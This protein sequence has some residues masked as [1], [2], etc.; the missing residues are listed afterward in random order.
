MFYGAITND[1]A[2]STL[3]NVPS[4][5]VSILIDSFR[6]QRKLWNTFMVETD[7]YVTTGFGK[8]VKN[9]HM[10][11]HKNSTKNYLIEPK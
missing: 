2:G 6:M 1:I 4:D 7:R 5:G 9:L 11:S 3:I 8:I 10:Y